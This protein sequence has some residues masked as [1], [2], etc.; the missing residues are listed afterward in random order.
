MNKYLILII[1]S[2]FSIS[3]NFAQSDKGYLEIKGV[4]KINRSPLPGARIVVMKEGVQ[5]KIY[6]V[7]EKGKFILRVDLGSHY[8]LIAEKQ[9]YYSKKLSFNTRI[10]DD[11]MG[12]WSYKFIVTMIPVIEGFDASLLNKPI[13]KIMYVEKVGEFDYDED[14]TFSMLKK[15]EALMKEYEKARKVEYKRL[16]AKADESFN[17][18]NYDEAIELYNKAIDIDPYETYPDDQM[19]AIEKIIAQDKNIQKN[20]DKNIAEADKYFNSQDYANAKKYYNR[21]LKYKKEKYPK[22]QIAEIERLLNDKDAMAAELAAKQKA[23]DDAIAAGDRM[24]TAK[25]YKEALNKYTGASKLKPSEQY[26]KTKITEI[27][28]IL[29]QL[30]NA[31]KNKAGIERAYKE[32]IAF[33]D[34]KF[35]DKDYLGALNYYKKASQIK[36]AEDYPKTKISEIN[37]I[38]AANKSLDEKYNNFITAADNAF[39]GK[40]YSQA[41]TYYQQA[42]GVKPNEE[43]PKSKIK[44]I[45]ILL[46][47]IAEKQKKDI[48]TNYL[49]LIATADDQFNKKDYTTAK[50]T[51]N[52]AL[53]VKNNEEYPKQ[54][55]AEI[56]K[57]L[58]DIA[59]KKD[60]YNKAIARADNNFNIEKWQEAKVDYQKALELF[61]NEQYPQTRINEIENKLL[62]LKNAKEQQIAREEAY[63]DAIAKGDALFIE[64]KY[65]E[66]K[67]SYSQALA[68]K[69][70]E[71]Y[72]KEKIAEIDNLL[73]TAKALDERY[74]KIIA[75]A[76]ELFMNEKYENAKTT[77]QNALNLKPDEVYPKQKISEINALLSAQKS[78][79]GK[80]NKA[81]ASADEF[82][83]NKK[84]SDAKT[85]YLNASQL[86]PNEQYPKQKIAEIDKIL[87]EQNSLNR[88]YD[89]IIATAN[90]LF[91]GE[92]Y[93]D[94]KTTYQN[95]LQL[96]PNE[97]YPKQ[98]ISEIDA[99]LS[100]LAAQKVKQQQAKQQYDKLIT[101]ADNQFASKNYKQAKTLYQQASTVLPEE[102][103]PKQKIVEIDDLLAGLADKDKKYNETITVANHNFDNKQYTEA[104]TNYKKAS[105]IKPNEQY[106]K[107][108]LA[109]SQRLLK[110]MQDIE[111]S[112]NSYIKLADLALANNSLESAKKNYQE[113]IKLKPAEQYPKNQLAH[114]EGLLAEKAKRE[115]D[116]A[117]INTQYK[118]LITSA[119]AKFNQK[120]YQSARADYLQASQLKSNEMYPKQKIAE[121]DDITQAIASQQKAYN[122]KMSEAANLFDSKNLQGAL[123][124][125]QDASKIKPDESLPKQKITEIQNIINENNKKLAQYKN[126]IN[127]ADNLFGQKKYNEAKTQYQKA[128]S[129]LPEKNYPKQ[130]IDKIDALLADIANKEAQ[131]KAQLQ[132]YN[133]KIAEADKLFNSKDYQNAISA[134]MDAKMIKPNETYPDQQVAKINNIIKQNAAKLKADYNN[135][136]AK[137]DN[138]K[139]S[140]D[141]TNALQQY[142]IALNLM[143]NDN[144]AKSKI[145]E[146]NSL[147]E[148]D[149][150]EKAKQEKLQ[151]EYKKYVSQGDIAFKSKDYP[152]AIGLYNKALSIKPNERY[153]TDR[154]D[155]CKQKIKEAKTLAAAEEEKR[156]QAQLAA[157]KK[158][159]DNKEFDYIGEK[160]DRKFL[161][162][163]AKQYPEG[164]TIE[165]YDKKNKKI[166]RVIVNRNGIAKE[167]IEVKYSYGTYYFRNGNNISRS[168]FYSE[169]KE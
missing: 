145:A 58:A 2:F 123:L 111:A 154:I 4:V 78:T 109:E 7:D 36:P 51:Y 9:G 93:K 95:A 10:P 54:R 86:K 42:L 71:S 157:S 150:L 56:D 74:N 138:F 133:N 112:Y 77:Y 146:V 155:L 3:S 30:A 25:Q 6:P 151:A 153:P 79:D 45:D 67:N 135:A 105:E 125:Y 129:V 108:R 65:Q 102:V 89:E 72:P 29:A 26:P 104:I 132:Q 87:E 81:I 55:I 35:T 143:P 73:I 83:N 158:S 120:N 161:N 156:R 169:T 52:Q 130:Q 33:A 166:K 61:P 18:K 114:V 91:M 22:N 28:T 159:F 136:I 39:T 66:A 48:E 63:S 101:S 41:K 149:R 80:Y 12:I 115:A 88:R 167:Y 103:Y 121:I 84:Y 118:N 162:E 44:E 163:L 11:E 137:G 90:N 97:Q 27:N 152:A 131:R 110:Q 13:G 92:K 127:Q 106:P 8:I 5:E 165:H 70:K 16:I 1:L 100:Q 46:L 37:N 107:Q 142:N 94:A 126:V 96:K 32:A 17:N 99:I 144:I 116:M 85:T 75:T 69:P 53:T 15:L 140:K 24:F 47:Q 134:Y 14:Y 164:V 50:S 139:N 113:A 20:Y 62:S 128:S 168:I 147:I 76:N 64:K 23:Y 122:Q 160:R 40:K 21:A 59:S 82:F 31:E 98:K 117:K 43:Y 68:V 49:R 141:Y 19:Y 57:I 119:D 148:K 124:A 60:A 38:L 34:T